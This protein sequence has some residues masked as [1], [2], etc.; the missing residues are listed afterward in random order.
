MVAI[1]FTGSEHPRLYYSNTVSSVATTDP[2]ENV[3][4]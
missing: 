3:E 2:G 1:S 4:K